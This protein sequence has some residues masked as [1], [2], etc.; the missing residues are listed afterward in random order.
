MRGDVHGVDGSRHIR[1]GIFKGLRE[2]VQPPQA[3]SGREAAEPPHSTAAAGRD[4][5]SPEALRAYWRKVGTKALK[6]F[7]LIYA[8]AP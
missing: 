7:D 2:D 4:C 1:H 8:G 3:R 5:S 6:Y